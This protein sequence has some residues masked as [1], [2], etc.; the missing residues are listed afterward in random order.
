MKK[1]AAMAMAAV[2]L[3]AVAGCAQTTSGTAEPVARTVV[4]APVV[5]PPA[6]A[7]GE[8][9]PA[10]TGT[11]DVHDFE[12]AADGLRPFLLTEAEIGPGF[13]SIA[14]PKPDPSAPA[15]C[16]GPGVVA[17]FPDAVR[18]G[19]AFENTSARVQEAVSVY[20]DK[21]TAQAAYDH[22]VAGLDCGQG[23]VGGKPVVVTPGEDL[24]VDVGGTQAIGWRVGGEG[25]DLLLI[26]VH[27]DEVVMT[28][29]WLTPEDGSPG[30][31]DPLVVTRGAVQ[32]LVG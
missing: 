9:P 22:S 10:S 25:F 5:P 12:A 2:A 21:A 26:T 24:R 11:P 14:E 23:S 4:A 28:F 8:A 1:Y 27:R 32:K 3:V 7:A 19:V 6:A 31:P 17:R 16:G 29:T 13:V 18:V 30:L 15:V 20:P